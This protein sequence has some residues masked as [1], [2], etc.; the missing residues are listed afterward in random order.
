MSPFIP[1]LLQVFLYFYDLFYKPKTTTKNVEPSLNTI[2]SLESVDTLQTIQ[3]KEYKLQSYDRLLNYSENMHGLYYSIPKKTKHTYTL[4]NIFFLII[5]FVGGAIALA[6]QEAVWKY[7]TENKLPI[8][9]I[10]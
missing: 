7:C 9:R 5:N 10:R 3:R 4:M 8:R 1:T 2:F 6:I